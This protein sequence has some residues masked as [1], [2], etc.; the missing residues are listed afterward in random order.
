MPPIFSLPAR[1][2]AVPCGWKVWARNSIQGD[3]RFADALGA[4]GARSRD[5]RQLDRGSRAPSQGRLQ[6]VRS[7][8]EPHSRRGHDAGGGG[9]VRRWTA[10]G[11]AT[12]RAGGSRKPIASRPWQRNCARSARQSKRARDYLF[13]VPPHASRASRPRGTS[14]PTTIIAWRC[15]FR[16]SRWA[17]SRSASTIPG[18]WPRLSR[19]I[20][21]VSPTIAWR[22]A[23]VPVIAI[24]GPSASGKGTVAQRSHRRLGFHYLDS[25]AL[26]RL[27]AL[28][29]MRSTDLRWTPKRLAQLADCAARRVSRQAGIWLNG[30]DVTEAI[31]TE[32]VSATASW[33]PRFPRTARAYRA[34]AGFRRAPGLVA[35]GRDMGT[36]VFPD[37]VLKVFLTASAE[38]RALRRYKQLI[39]KGFDANLA[40]LLQEFSQR[41]ERDSARSVAPLQKSA[42]AQVLDTT[43]LSIEEAT[44]P[45]APVVRVSAASSPYP[46]EPDRQP[47]RKSA[48]GRVCIP[49]RMDLLT[50][51]VIC[52]GFF[53]E[54]QLPI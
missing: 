4:M 44:V 36:V 13:V 31:R 14:T 17:V 6:R 24:D 1:S 26:Y 40:A 11:C 2:A 50:N 27:V 29:A 5:G 43:G 25:G 16:W 28:A 18:A 20:S 47:W 51:P 49:L 7:R 39:D 19:T 34:P 10:A 9:P 30:E 35:D 46:A 8:S 52:N 42:E 32:E 12:S 33:S 48:S 23:A 21:I 37:A 38:E 53:S 3:V 54:T 15:A 22:L 45:S 41:D